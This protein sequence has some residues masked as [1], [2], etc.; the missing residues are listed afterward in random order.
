MALPTS[1]AA[2]AVENVPVLIGR[3]NASDEAMLTFSELEV[4][5]SIRG[6]GGTQA[7]AVHNFVGGGRFI[8]KFGAFPHELSWSGILLGANALTRAYQLDSLRSAGDKV[9]FKWAQW[10]YTGLISQF[11]IVARHD[12][13]LDYSITFIPET[14]SSAQPRPLINS[15]TVDVNTS[16][17]SALSKL[18]QYSILPSMPA[19][20]VAL[21]G[22]ATTVIATVQQIM[23]QNGN[24]IS[25]AINLAM[26]PSIATLTNL[27]V[28][29]TGLS[30][31][32]VGTAAS[33]ITSAGVATTPQQAATSAAQAATFDLGAQLAN[34]VATL[35]AG[36]TTSSTLSQRPTTINVTN[37]N[38]FQ[39]AA[40]FYGDVNQWLILSQA[41]GNIPPFNVG[42]FTL[43]IP[44]LPTSGF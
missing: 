32:L 27:A 6:I 26:N 19:A 44:P 17:G 9:K 8:D 37:P 23:A 10:T 21:I 15:Q 13:W 31:T 12:G 33:G 22:Q 29:F 4:P 25:S 28:S 16:I 35:T 5:E 40:Q 7:H 2:L 30:Y 24:L 14:D 41:N 3:L 39:L 42:N 38:L 34:L 18:K 1:I 43:K 36:S 11:D 20:V